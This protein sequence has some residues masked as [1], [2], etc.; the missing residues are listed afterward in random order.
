MNELSIEQLE[1]LNGLLG[2][3]GN[4]LNSERLTIAEL[5]K[6]GND[7]AVQCYL[8]AKKALAHLVKKYKGNESNN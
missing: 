7:D 5:S 4:M 8:L 3:A 2:E 6:R 1:Q